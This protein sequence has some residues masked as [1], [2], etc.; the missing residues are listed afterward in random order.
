[1]CAGGIADTAK[2]AAVQIRAC[3]NSM[4]AIKTTAAVK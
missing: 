1:M 4:T 3:Y 2:Y